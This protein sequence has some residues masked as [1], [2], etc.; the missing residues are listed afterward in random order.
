VR[1]A[2]RMFTKRIVFP[3]EPEVRAD[4]SL[5][6]VTDIESIRPKLEEWG[7]DPDQPVPKIVDELNVQMSSHMKAARKANAE[8]AA[9]E[10][11]MAEAVR[12]ILSRAVVI[13]GQAA[14]EYGDAQGEVDLY[15]GFGCILPPWEWFWIEHRE[16]TVEIGVLGRRSDAPFTT[17]APALKINQGDQVDECGRWE[18]EHIASWDDVAHVTELTLFIRGRSSADDPSG[19][20][21]R[22]A[23]ALD[24]DGHAIDFHYFGR[25]GIDPDK[26]LNFFC[27]S[28][29][30]LSLANCRNITTEAHRP[31]PR[32][33]RKHERTHG[34]PLF[35][36]HTLKLTPGRLGPSTA[37]DGDPDASGLVRGHIRRGS[38]HHYGD[39]CPGRHE[40]NGLL[41]GRITGRVFVPDHFA[42]NPRRGAV[43][44]DR[45]V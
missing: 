11:Q 13:D 15:G 25:F 7:I 41:F 32:L 16:A 33:S 18:S 1:L 28:L 23:I 27:T 19:P 9:A 26:M 31:P 4:D 14:A 8:I 30:T 5:D 40:P 10:R 42:G 2:D 35:T 45:S 20:L 6:H 21:Y 44:T 17:D 34:H 43:V 24:A 12:A 36:Y 29:W 38:I 37:G 3:R 22:V 39:C